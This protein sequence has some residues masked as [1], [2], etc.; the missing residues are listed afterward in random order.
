MST[1]KR[2]SSSAV[3]ANADV[4]G[5]VEEGANALAEPKRAT[6]GT[7]VFMVH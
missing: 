1:P 5:A 2:L 6:R 3:A 4:L 7:I